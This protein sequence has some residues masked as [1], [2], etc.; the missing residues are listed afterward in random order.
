VL[1]WLHGRIDSFS[2]FLISRSFVSGLIL[3]QVVFLF[4]F[5]TLARAGRGKIATQLASPMLLCGHNETCL[6]TVIGE[7]TLIQ[8]LN[9]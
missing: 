4:T 8:K 1:L 9:N 5:R 2:A 7:C 6:R 3:P